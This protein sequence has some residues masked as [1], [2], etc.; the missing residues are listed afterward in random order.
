MRISFHLGSIDI[1][2]PIDQQYCISISGPYQCLPGEDGEEREANKARHCLDLSPHLSCIPYITLVFV[3]SNWN[4]YHRTSIVIV[5]SGD[6][7][8]VFT[9]SII[10]HRKTRHRRDISDPRNSCCHGQWR[11]AGDE[12]L[13]EEGEIII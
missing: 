2:L 3:T 10:S 13:D 7:R 1:F 5:I 8:K 12:P 4:F 11:V 6:Q 9:C